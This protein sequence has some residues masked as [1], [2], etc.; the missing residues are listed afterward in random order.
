[1]PVLPLSSGDGPAAKP[2]QRNGCAH[3]PFILPMSTLL[4]PLDQS[5]FDPPPEAVEFYVDALRL[6]K[7]SAF[8][9]LLSG[10]YA[11]SC[12]TGITRPTKDLDIFCK[13]SDAPKILNFFQDRGY[14]I[15]IEDERWIGKV[16]QGEHFFDVIYNISSASIP[17]TEEWFREEYEGIVYGTP[18]R[19]TP[20][21]QFILSKL[22]LQTRYR[23]DMADIV[24]VILKKHDQI[25]WKWLLDQLELYWEV[26]LINL[27]NFRFVYPSERDL[28]PNWLM[29][30]LLERLKAQE[31]MPPSSVRI[32]R[33]RLVSPTDFVVDVSEWGFADVVGKGIDE[34]HERPAH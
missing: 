11:L 3:P 21:T 18:V 30:E 4:P 28:I 23:Y 19:I 31:A 22:F 13:P 12:Y 8:P 7:E 33:G 20:P 27:L 34:K 9:F 14:T 1:M 2:R 32:C 10:T 29:D 26:L 17:I 6:L 25:D 16:W 15:S 5:V 24:H